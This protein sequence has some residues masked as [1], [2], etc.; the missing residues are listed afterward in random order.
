MEWDTE[1]KERASSL[2][3]KKNFLEKGT[4]ALVFK[5]EGWYYRHKGNSLNYNASVSICL[6]LSKHF[7]CVATTCR[8]S[9]R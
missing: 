9:Q 3:I 2:G 5:D 1:K 8:T 7:E 6:A 4:Q